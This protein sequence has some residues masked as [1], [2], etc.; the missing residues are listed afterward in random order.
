MTTTA[1]IGAPAELAAVLRPEVNLCLW[2]REVPAALRRFVDVNLARRDC[3]RLTT[4]DGN[5]PDELTWGVGLADA[6]DYDAFH[7]DVTMLSRLYAELTGADRLT[8]KLEAFAGSLCERL[9][10]DRVGL[11]LICSY[12]GPGTEWLAN[13]DVDRRWLG[14]ADDR[15]LRLGGA[16]RRM[17][18]WS[19]G[20]MKGERWP[21]N[22]GNGLV[23]RSPKCAA[24]ERRV[25][26][27]IEQE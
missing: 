26:L 4:W 17:P 2:Q 24:G 6:E 22:A 27:K 21:G 8:I 23:H 7:D 3:K 20:L 12:A 1:D 5:E 11:R 19:V 16:V 13:A 9:H 14:T 10:V 25:L 15:L 18:R